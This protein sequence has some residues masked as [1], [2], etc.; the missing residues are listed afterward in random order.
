[1]SHHEISRRRTFAII[2]H[3]DAGKTTLTE[4]LLLYGG[5][6]QLAGAVKAKRGRANAVS[7]WM[8]M[9]RERG[10]SITTSV[11]QFPYRGLQMNLLD[12]PGHADFSEDTYRTLHA[13][14]GAVMLLDCAKGV[15]SQTRKLFRVCRQRSIPIFTFVNKMDRP[16]RDAFELI[17]EVESV[18]GIGVYPITWPVFRSG[19]FR[20]VY[21]RMARRVYL[22]D[23]DH[24]NSSSTTGAERPPVEVTGID[25]PML[26]EALD[27]A[28]YDRLR[29]EAD[30]LDAAGDGFDR[31]R[32]EAGELSPMFFGSAVNNF[33]LEAFL[34]TFSEL[35]PPPRPRDTDQGPVEP[36]RDEFSG[37]VFKIQANMDKAH[38]DRVAFV[39]ICSGRMV[40]GMKA[41]HVRTGKDVR[42]ANPTQFLARDRN[43][44]DESWAGDVV[45]I[46][47]PGNLEIG[48]TL[49]GGSRF[50]YEGIPSFA[51]EHFR[52]LALV[53]PM[54]RKQFATGLEQ[55]AQE[56][57]VQLYRPP[58]GRA[59]DLVL[60]ALGQLQFEVVR[61][62]LESEYS[63]Q[64]RVEPVPYQLARWVSRADGKPL[65][66][67]ALHDAVEG[68]VV[69]DVRDRPVVLFDREWALRTAER[70]HP[71]YRFAE[72]A[73]GVVV[74]AA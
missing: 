3:P 74:R 6:I 45:G 27:D 16:G 38:R 15:E 46:H 26:R 20:G 1:M 39:R 72:T 55:L 22:F 30:L 2:A 44:V 51:P 52:R 67:D 47:D 10:I 7:D 24:A 60:G 36:T 65:D 31:E 28:G 42:L 73:T 33:G 56:G 58:A 19:V 13:V 9:E 4:K 21:H 63:V 14:D 59:G 37:F 23:A 17:G 18:L 35:M 71:E 43:V 54:R 64:V 29:S 61:Y 11:L 62:R 25:D 70:L 57:T 32:F 8:E 69:L 41:H 34:E 49:T 40:R 5:V 66:L 53:D 48:D 68:M 12:T 50:V